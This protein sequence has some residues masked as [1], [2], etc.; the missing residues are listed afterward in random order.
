MYVK[1]KRL[2]VI[3]K[4]T[5]IYMFFIVITS[6]RMCCFCCC[7]TLQKAMEHILLKTILYKYS[8]REVPSFIFRRVSTSDLYIKYTDTH[9]FTR[10]E[11]IACRWKDGRG[12]W[13][14]WLNDVYTIKHHKYLFNF[15]KY[16][17]SH[18]N[19][20]FGEFSYEKAF[21]MAVFLLMKTYSA[22]EHVL[23]DILLLLPAGLYR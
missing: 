13:L 21:Y 19:H 11:I 4:Y 9:P 15:T 3:F 2:T 10:R 6:W 7:R 16:I 5:Y 1:V 20:W 14:G 23:S 12:V 17:S 8:I 18:R 22:S